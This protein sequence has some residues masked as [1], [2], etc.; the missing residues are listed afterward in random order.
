LK[1]CGGTENT[2][3]V[4][5]GKKKRDRKIGRGRKKQRQP[6]VL[7]M[8]LPAWVLMVGCARMGVGRRSRVA[9]NPPI[10]EE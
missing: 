8:A 4:V 6:I 5:T 10:W 2:S 9:A 7:Y 1:I 3:G